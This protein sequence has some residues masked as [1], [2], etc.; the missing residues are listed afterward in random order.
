MKIFEYLHLQELL[1]GV[2]TVVYFMLLTSRTFALSSSYLD[3]LP[4]SPFLLVSVVG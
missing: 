1:K 4:P 3:T 2:G